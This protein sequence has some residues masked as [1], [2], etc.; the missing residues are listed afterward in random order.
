[1]KV[2]SA[3]LIFPGRGWPG[4]YCSLTK[5]GAECLVGL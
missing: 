5:A 2:L 4:Y 1:M 3:V